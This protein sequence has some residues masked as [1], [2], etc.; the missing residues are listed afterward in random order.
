[1][2]ASFVGRSNGIRLGC[3]V[4]GALALDWGLP[5]WG[6]YVRI[7]VWNS[8]DLAREIDALTVARSID[9]VLRSNEL[10]AYDDAKARSINRAQ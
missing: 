4:L 8:S 9:C 6:C 10:T 5:S 7:G 3:V 2:V 1:M